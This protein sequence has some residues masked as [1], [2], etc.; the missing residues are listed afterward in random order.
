MSSKTQFS[1][2]C[3]V[4]VILVAAAT[5]D[6]SSASAADWKPDKRVEIVVPN[7]AGGGNDR[8]AR[9]VQKIAQESRWVDPVMT[10]INKPGAGVVVGLNYLNQHPGD[11]HYI[12]IISATFLADYIT[13]RSSLGIADITPLAQLFTEYVAF[14]VKPDS[15]IKSGKDLIAMLK[16][17]AGSVR[18]AI[19]GGIGNHNYNSPALVAPAAGGDVQQ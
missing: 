7:A 6:C 18:T 2:L 19:A 11:G 9:L 1:A 16:T 8:I 17:E 3:L 14:A 4:L 10:V 12:G 13:G 5:T 15:A